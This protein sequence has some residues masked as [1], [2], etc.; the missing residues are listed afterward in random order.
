M[1]DTLLATLAKLKHKIEEL[2]SSEAL[3][4]QRNSDLEEE[5]AN[6]RRQATEADTARKKAELD[7]EF[8]AVSHKLADSPDTLA[9]A[10][11]RL[12]GLIR[13]IDRCLDMLKE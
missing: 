5:N 4:M 1:A 3:L 10:R 6:L 9:T 12:S 8:L 11:R 13:N 7:K 2:K